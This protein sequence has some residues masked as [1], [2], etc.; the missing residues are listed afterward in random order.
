ML[1]LIVGPKGS[2]K[3]KVFMEQINEAIKQENGDIVCL[4]RGKRLR[5]DIPHSVRLVETDDYE[6]TGFELLSAFSAKSP[7]TGLA[8]GGVA[9]LLQSLPSYALS[10]STC[11]TPKRLAFCL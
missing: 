8:T 1:K 4:E 2:G 10:P 9:V 3:T 5:F 11:P 7:T 6:I